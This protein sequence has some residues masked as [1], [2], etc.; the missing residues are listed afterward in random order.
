MDVNDTV[1]TVTDQD[2]AEQLATAAALL[3][4]GCVELLDGD[5]A[6]LDE[7][8]AEARRR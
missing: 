8:V 7:H 1:L 4:Q 6:A 5:M 3:T 2:F